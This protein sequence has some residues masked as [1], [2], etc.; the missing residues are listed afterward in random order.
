MATCTA[1]ISLCILDGNNTR[2][3]SAEPPVVL[4]IDKPHL[5]PHLQSEQ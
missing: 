5:Q 3:I 1:D 2:H 4:S